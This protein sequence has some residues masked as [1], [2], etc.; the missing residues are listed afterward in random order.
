[1]NIWKSFFQKPLVISTQKYE[2]T[3]SITTRLLIFPTLFMICFNLCLCS[4]YMAEFSF[5][6][7]REDYIQI[8]TE[9]KIWASEENIYILML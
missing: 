3:F 2:K 9:H 5:I 6:V 4:M 8:E 7:G 1:M